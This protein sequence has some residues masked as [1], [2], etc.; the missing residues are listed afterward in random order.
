[1]AKSRSKSNK[2]IE[3]V[4]IIV[5]LII[6]LY[7][8]F[9]YSF[10]GIIN[11]Q[12][13]RNTRFISTNTFV[14]YN[15][16]MNPQFYVNRSNIFFYK[17]NY[18]YLYDANGNLNWKLMHS[19]EQGIIL[20][21][22][23]VVAIA[24]PKGNIMYIIDTDGIK[25]T[26]L[27]GYPILTFAVNNQG[28][29]AVILEYKGGYKINVYDTQGNLQ[30]ERIFKDNNVFPIAIDISYD[31]LIVAVS[32]LDINNSEISSNILFFYIDQES[33]LKQAN[34]IFGATG[35]Q[36]GQVIGKLN[37]MNNNQLIAVSNNKILSIST[38]P[39]NLLNIDWYLKFEKNV[40]HV[41]F[42]NN[43]AIAIAYENGK[44]E[45]YDYLGNFTGSHNVG[46]AINFM[47][48]SLGHIIVGTG[49][50]NR[51][52]YA[53]NTIGRVLWEHRFFQEVNEVM[54]LNRTNRVMIKTPI[55]AQILERIE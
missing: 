49:N 46:S 39:E 5:P 44:I 9:G 4:L 42:L 33:N 10:F 32:L 25:Y 7:I 17:D 52:F 27:F 18:M 15:R 19:V 11:L 2:V 30:L 55:N 6:I 1:M 47:S 23:N 14:E 22:E 20:G 36:E 54:F 41:D 29:S 12:L 8:I 51:Q 35:Q 45:F 53:I 13:Q 48:G 43:M 28:I 38:K 26:K 31:G 34:E 24:K 37:F 40:T 16:G 21:S 3:K 50:L